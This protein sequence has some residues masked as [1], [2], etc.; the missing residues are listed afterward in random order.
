MRIERPVWSD[1]KE[2]KQLCAALDGHARFVGGCVRDALTGADADDIDMATPFEPSEVKA[3]L[4]PFFPVLP[5]GTAHGTQTVLLNDGRF[6]KAEVTTLRKDVETDGRHAVVAFSKDWR[7]DASR[8]DLTINALYAD[9]EGNVFDYFNGAQDL[10][11]GV[12]RFIGRP[13]DR[14]REDYLRVLRYF[15]F[16]ARF[17][18]GGADEETLAACRAGLDGVK[19]LSVDRLRREFF[20]LTALKDAAKGL[21]AADDAGLSELFFPVSPNIHV[22][23]RFIKYCPSASVLWRFSALLPFDA[24]VRA[25]FCRHWKLSRRDSAKLAGADGRFLS[26]NPALFSENALFRF[27]AVYGDEAET[28]AFLAAAVTKNTAWENVA[29]AAGKLS[30]P[31]FRFSGA[32]VAA[33]GVSGKRTGEILS[34]VKELWLSENGQT[35]REELLSFMKGLL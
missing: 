27:K 12:V 25:D 6:K 35:P 33:A 5:T 13:S 20:A 22:L 19:K 4:E 16:Y 9:F 1:S 7:E 2:L 15:R 30:L 32:D 11:D 29:A 8:R 34:A 10:A 31:P 17:G 23:E 28:A 18:K 26:Q 14:I 3:R 24:Q 21:R